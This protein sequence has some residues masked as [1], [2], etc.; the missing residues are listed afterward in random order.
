MLWKIQWKWRP[1]ALIMFPGVGRRGWTKEVQE[2]NHGVTHVDGLLSVE[3][4]WPRLVEGSASA[5]E[6][7]FKMG[8]ENWVV[9][10]VV[11]SS[12]M[13]MSRWPESEERR[14]LVMTLALCSWESILWTFN[15]FIGCHF[16]C[17]Q[18]VEY[19]CCTKPL[20]Q[21]T[22]GSEKISC[23]CL[24]MHCIQHWDLFYW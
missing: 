7:G 21:G 6:E 4:I 8:E 14:R 19:L 1:Y 2:W 12:I 17:D 13:R 20:F 15:S 10:G 24:K 11:R 18:T 9:D 3:E 22:L 16:G 23:L 5:A